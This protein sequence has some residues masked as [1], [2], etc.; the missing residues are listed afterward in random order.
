MKKILSA[1]LIAA[2]SAAGGFQAANFQAEPAA[3]ESAAQQSA[4]PAA[5]AEPTPPA[6]APADT[7]KLI[8]LS[9]L[10]LSAEDLPGT[11]FTVVVREVLQA[12]ALDRDKAIL[13]QALE[14]YKVLECADRHQRKWYVL[15]VG[16]FDS[17]GAAQRAAAL[18]HGNHGFNAVV[19]K[20]PP[21]P[22]Q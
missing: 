14:A 2:L 16:E 19:K 4:E 12:Q 1:V 10:N 9:A 5:E 15:S 22:A 13:D 6:P 17:R 11:V 21:P 8:P 20:L 3:E 18:L 7:S